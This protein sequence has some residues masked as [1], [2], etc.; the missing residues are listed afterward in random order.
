[1]HRFNDIHTHTLGRPL[2]VLS[3]PVSG[4]EGI[5]AANAEVQREDNTEAQREGNADAQNSYS[6]RVSGLQHYSL[7]LH[8]WHLTDEQD[9][10][11]YI[12]CARRLANDPCFVAL[13]ECGLDPLCSTPLPLQHKAF[14]AALHLAKELHKPLV[15]HC[16]RLWGEL[17]RDVQQ[18]LTPA[19][20]LALPLIIHGYR[21][22]PQ[23]AQQLLDAGF[24]ISLGT[25]YN[26]QVMQLIPT[27]RLY[28]ET[29]ELPSSS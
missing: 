26:E 2:S 23:L 5:V 20:C 12:A 28:K 7:Q 24:S 14:L 4:V 10:D 16:V 29:D 17:I 9:I 19:E 11:A 22:G 6:D 8:P 18:V 15:I 3:I 1:M 21:K 13:G 27:D 25:H